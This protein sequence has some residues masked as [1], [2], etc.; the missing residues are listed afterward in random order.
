MR[1]DFATNEQ[2]LRWILKTAYAAEML[3]AADWVCNSY[4]KQ[5]VRPG[6]A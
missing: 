3:S 2:A 6:T 1:P 5:P 4:L